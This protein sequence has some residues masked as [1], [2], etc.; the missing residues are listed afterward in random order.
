MELPSLVNSYLV[1]EFRYENSQ[2][3]PDSGSIS[4]DQQLRPDPTFLQIS[5]S[6][7]RTGYTYTTGSEIEGKKLFP[8]NLRGRLLPNLVENSTI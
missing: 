3:L 1:Y 5:T 8:S 6:F 4:R 7:V 2:T